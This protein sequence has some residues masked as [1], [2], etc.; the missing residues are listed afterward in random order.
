MLLGRGN[1]PHVAFGSHVAVGLELANLATRVE[2]PLSSD[3]LRRRGEEGAALDRDGPDEVAMATEGPQLLSSVEVPLGRHLER[4]PRV[5][6]VQTAG[7]SSCV[8][9]GT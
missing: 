3:A 1:R 8:R 2:G 7:S 5:K 4:R 9:L 6:S